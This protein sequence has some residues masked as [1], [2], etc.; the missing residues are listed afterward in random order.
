MH[1]A[2]VPDAK[3]S[4]TKPPQR[5][6][7][8]RTTCFHSYRKDNHNDGM[9]LVL[10]NA[11]WASLIEDGNVQRVAID[12]NAVVRWAYNYYKTGT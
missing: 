2:Q 6:N 11:Q 5:L 12:M 7:C 1:L 3:R 9:M 8:I 4:Q 10:G